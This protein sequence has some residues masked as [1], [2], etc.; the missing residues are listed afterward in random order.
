[1]EI[2][3]PTDVHSLHLLLLAYIEFFFFQEGSQV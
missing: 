3:A 1:M 2:Y